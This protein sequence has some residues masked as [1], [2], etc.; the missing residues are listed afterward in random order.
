[1]NCPCGSGIKYND[2]CGKYHSGEL[3]DKALQLM[4]SR[5]SAYA[6]NLADYIMETTHPEN[7][8]YR[9]EKQA[10]KKAIRQF[11]KETLFDALT[12]IDF[13]DGEEEAYVTF[14]AQLRKGLQDISFTERSKFLKVNGKWLY[15]SGVFE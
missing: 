1:M 10:W 12:I 13:T 9:T 2:C 14:R 3:P 15:H 6:L 7:P 5:F 4:R 11:S 8:S